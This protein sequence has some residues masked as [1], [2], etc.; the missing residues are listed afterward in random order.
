MAT[1][2]KEAEMIANL[3]RVHGVSEDAVDRSLDALR[4]SGGTMAQF[5]HPDFGGCRNGLPA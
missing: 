1:A 3:A 5:S 4:R 2:P